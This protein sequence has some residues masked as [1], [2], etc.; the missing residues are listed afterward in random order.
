MSFRSG[1][2]AL[3][4]STTDLDCV[5]CTIKDVIEHFAARDPISNDEEATVQMRILFLT[6]HLPSPPISGGSARMHGLISRLEPS[7]DVAILSYRERAQDSRQA[8]ESTGQYARLVVTVV[9]PNLGVA[10]RSKRRGQLRSL[11]SRGSFERRV[12]GLPALQRAFDRVVHEWRPDV[13]VVEFAQ[14]GYLRFPPEIPVI[15]DA[16]N[17]EHEILRRSARVDGSWSRSLYSRI[18]AFKLRRE[19]ANLVRRV[20]GLSVTSERDR[21]EFVQLVPGSDPVV[22]PNGVD[23]DHFGSCHVEPDDG[24]VLFFGAMDYFP[25]VD[26]V[27]YFYREIWPQLRRE[28][29]DLQFSVVGRDPA[30][31]VQLLDDAPGVKVTGLVDDLREWIGRAA[32]VIVPL[33]A[34]SGT[35]LKV[36]EA[37]AMGKPVVSTSLG[38]EGLDVVHGE[39]VLIA[40]DPDSF[41]ASVSLLLESAEKRENMGEAA[42]KLVETSYD[43]R[44][45]SATFE[46]MIESVVA[47]RQDEDTAVE[48]E[49]E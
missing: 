33:R 10:S 8:V 39:H 17:V 45:I 27:T 16:H 24:I 18:N 20:D 7:H 6:P 25:N 37:M 38:V 43:W 36:L 15:L 41:A 35:R 21:R 29:P 31:D 13:I 48:T 22:I 3:N 40:D 14:M 47:E 2:D 5:G 1:R 44:E 26:A 23:C 46:R 42:R 9:N 49:T 28:H 12:Y 30:P 32:V 19:E 11:V 4:S 34:G